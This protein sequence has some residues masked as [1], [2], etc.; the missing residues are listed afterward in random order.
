[1]IHFSTDYVF[2]GKK[3]EYV[4]TDRVNPLNRYGLTKS[5]GEKFVLEYPKSKVFR[6]QTVYS[7]HNTNFYKSIAAKALADEP[8]SVVS[9][10]FMAP[11]SATWIAQQVYRTLDVPQYGLYHL[12]PKGF[13]SFADFAELI[14]ATTYKTVYN[15]P[16][17]PVKRI[18]YKDLNSIVQRPLVTIMNHDKFNAAFH[19][20]TDTWE[21]VYN[22]FLSKITK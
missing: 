2:D 19:P 18:H 5:I 11:T 21:D 17:L 14:Y 12:T 3:N 13:C 7:K 15:K 10:Q 1:M 6:V 20:I 4:E 9:D 22:T 16:S 8:A